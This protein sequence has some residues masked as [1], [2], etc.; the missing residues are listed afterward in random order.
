MVKCYVD[1]EIGKFQG[2]IFALIADK[3]P[4]NIRDEIL[5]NHA[6]TLDAVLK[7]RVMND[8][9]VIGYYFR[10]QKEGYKESKYP[11]IK[12][13]LDFIFREIPKKD[14]YPDA[15]NTGFINK[16]YPDIIND[17]NGLLMVAVLPYPGGDK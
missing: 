4:S 17:E 2:N 5:S 15:Y 10:C 12:T 8:T 3:F 1:Y 6:V 13:A 16:S 14:G 7:M 9:K 11:T